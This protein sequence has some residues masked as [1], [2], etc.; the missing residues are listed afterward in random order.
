MVSVALFRYDCG[1]VDYISDRLHFVLDI[2]LPEGIGVSFYSY[3]LCC[4]VVFATVGNL[5]VV[6]C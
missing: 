6:L 3:I 1:L 2:F 5:I 4:L